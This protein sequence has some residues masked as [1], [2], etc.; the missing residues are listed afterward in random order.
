ML[1]FF[2]QL[3]GDHQDLHYPLRRQRQMCIRDSSESNKKNV[4]EFGNQGQMNENSEGNNDNQVGNDEGDSNT[5]LILYWRFDEGKGNTI[6]DLSNNNNQG[7]LIGES[8]I[9]M[10]LDE[11]DPLEI[12]DKW[13]Q[14][15]PKQF[16]LNFT[17]QEKISLEKK[18]LVGTDNSGK[19]FSLELWIKPKIEHK[20]TLINISGVFIVSYN[21]QNELEVMIN[22]NKVAWKEE[23]QQQQQSNNYGDEEGY[24]NNYNEENS[25]NLFE[26][27]WNHIALTYSA[28]NQKLYLYINTN[29][30]LYTELALQPDIFKG[31]NFELS[32]N[33]F[34]GEITEVR[35]WKKELQLDEIKDNYRMP[36]EF[37]YEKKKNSQFVLKMKQKNEGTSKESELSKFAGLAGLLAKGKEEPNEKPQQ[38]QQQDQIEQPSAFRE[39]TDTIHFASP[40]KL[41]QSPINP[42]KSK[43]EQQQSQQSQQQEEM[44]FSQK[45]EESK[46]QSASNVWDAFE[47]QKQQDPQLLKSS[48][49]FGNL[50]QTP[51]Q[52]AMKFSDFS[53]NNFG[54]DTFSQ[55]VQPAQPQSANFSQFAFGSA[56]ETAKPMGN[57]MKISE[58]ANIQD[59]ANFGV[60]TSPKKEE[61]I[62]ERNIQSVSSKKLNEEQFQEAQKVGIDQ[63]LNEFNKSIDKAFE[64]SK[65]QDKIQNSFSELKNTHKLL[66]QNNLILNQ[67]F[68]NKFFCIL[69]NPIDKQSSKLIYMQLI[70]LL[71]LCGVKQ[72][73]NKQKEILIK[74]FICIQ[75]QFNLIQSHSIEFIIQLKALKEIFKLETLELLMDL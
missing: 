70:K 2:F 45:F 21:Q 23:V 11:G 53:S 33:E 47:T 10:K 5:D 38:Q 26:G 67:Q 66:S 60:D 65:Q 13:G 15:C 12:E 3:Y 6:E 9:W 57:S 59:F 25:K 1:F 34:I 37:V 41:N 39:I 58:F 56:N 22:Q 16:S 73:I 44:K 24:Q 40:A 31:G 27:N 30:I 32:C 35:F 69:I 28:N 19:N 63:L 43:F 7:V 62:I 75:S 52:S 49:G 17:Q 72:R 64:F 54:F 29:T 51:G 61:I 74:K 71:L 8:N 20:A 42:Q 46:S 14:K 48:S 55:N 4:D 18:K 68:K 36:L 50:S